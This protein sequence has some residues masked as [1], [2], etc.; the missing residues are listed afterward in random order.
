L[1][2]ELF[3]KGKGRKL[4]RAQKLREIAKGLNQLYHATN[5][6]ARFEVMAAND[7]LKDPVAAGRLLNGLLNFV[8]S[9]S[10][11]TF[12]GLSDAV[13]SLPADADGSRVHTWPNV[14]ILPFLADPTA[15]MVLKPTIT[16]RMARRLQFQLLYSSTPTWHCYEALLRMTA[17]LR[18]RLEPLGAKDNIDVQSFIWVTQ[19]LE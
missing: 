13:A 1:Y 8:E 9:P 3:G 17:E 12:D 16:K 6:P 19:D 2:L 7:G 14:T 4:L 18:E 11:T 10:A 15:L 5:I